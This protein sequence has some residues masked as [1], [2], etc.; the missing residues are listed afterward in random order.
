[1]V[2]RIQLL[3]TKILAF[4]KNKLFFTCLLGSLFA[5]YIF[6]FCSFGGR[7][8]LNLISYPV[9]AVL[10]IAVSF[11]GFVYFSEIKKRLTFLLIPPV[12]FVFIVLATTI[13]GTRDFSYL[14][15]IALLTIT[16]YLCYCCY[17]CFNDL[18]LIIYLIAIP[19]FAFGVYYFIYYFNDIIHYSGQRLGS[20]FGN[21]ND[22]GLNLYFGF[23]L[24]GI[25]AFGFRQFWMIPCS[26]FLLFV[27]VTTGSKKV[28]IMSFAFIIFLICVLLRKR[29]LILLITLASVVTILV[30]LFSLPALSGIRNRLLN[31]LPFFSST[32]LDAS[33]IN[34]FLF[35]QSSIYLGTKSFIFGYGGGAF[36][37][38]SGFGAYAHNNLGETLCDFGI[39]GVMAFYTLYP[40]IAFFTR[41]NKIEHFLY[42]YGF[43]GSFI[44]CSFTSVF[45]D[46]KIYYV[47]LALSIFLIV[48]NLKVLKEKAKTRIMFY[49]SRI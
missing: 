2:K 27:S 19:V 41:K 38:L 10:L 23:L 9:L 4:K 45:F 25:L 49:E 16:F 24:C 22:V 46:T 31:G 42:N 29:K 15:T 17:I 44:F 33:T 20:F 5:L 37:L 13:V 12:I 7:Q 28:I 48:D 32:N 21:E 11:F 8:K 39:F 18:K 35:F 36:A 3:K 47:L 26:L 30:I 1:M 43:L 14:K 34:R 6:T 40:T